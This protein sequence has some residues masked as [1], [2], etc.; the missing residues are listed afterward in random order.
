VPQALRE[1][2]K[3]Y[4]EDLECRK[5]IRRP[6]SEWRNPIRGLENS[7]GTIR[8]V[9]NFIP[10]NY[11]VLKGPYEIGS[12]KKLIQATQG[13]KWFI[14]IY[15]KAGFYHI[16]IGEEDKYKTAFK[17]YGKVYECNT[18]VIGFKNTP[19]VLQRVMSVILEK[20][21]GRGIA[22]YMD[23]LVVHAETVEQHDR[24][25]KLALKELSKHNMRVNYTKLQYRKNKVKVL[26]V[27]IDENVKRP[28]EIK[29]NKALEYPAPKSISELRR[30]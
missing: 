17:Y 23:D 16:E 3:R 11:L 22:V 14:F 18:M 19:Q 2:T 24:L 6:S 7:D 13:S 28:N 12:I 9:S 8:L 20:F 15:L 29:Q 1:K 21:K 27:N 26:G 30:F 4:L 25:F 10:V 5:V